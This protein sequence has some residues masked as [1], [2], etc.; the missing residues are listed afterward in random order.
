M[1]ITENQ[2]GAQLDAFGED[3]IERVTDL[4]HQGSPDAIGPALLLALG[5]RESG[6]RNIAGDFGHG[7]GWLQIDD[8]FHREF[9][10][11][12]KGCDSGKWDARHDSSLPS[13]RV[14]ALTASTLYAIELLHDNMRVAR[15]NGVP[16]SKVLRFAIAAYNAGAG[17]ALRGLRLGNVDR[18]TTGQDYS[19]DVLSRKAAVGRYLQRHALVA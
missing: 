7:R 14:P 2:L 8:R 12:H 17:G 4:A 5:S 18:N 13:G 6:L 11:T 9:L 15:N 1:N 19:R 10:S 3:R 16:A